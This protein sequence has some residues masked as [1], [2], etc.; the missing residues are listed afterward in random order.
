M[1]AASPLSG[2]SRALAQVALGEGSPE[3]RQLRRWHA[4]ERAIDGASPAIREGL[5]AIDSEAL[6]ADPGPPGGT[7]GSLGRRFRERARTGHQLARS[8]FAFAQSASIWATSASRSA[9]F[10]SGRI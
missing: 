6:A 4:A 3:G 5:D 1:L 8:A 9:N 10:A 2:A 7:S